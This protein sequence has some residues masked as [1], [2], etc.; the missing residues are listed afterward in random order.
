MRRWT[1]SVLVQIMSCRLGG[2]KPLSEPMQTYCNGI[3]LNSNISIQ[4]NAFKHVVCKVAAIFVQGEMSLAHSSNF[5]YKVNIKTL[6]I[7]FKTMHF[8]H[9]HCKKVY[10]CPRPRCFNR[11]FCSDSIITKWRHHHCPRNITFSRCPE[12]VLPVTTGSTCFSANTMQTMRQQWV[13]SSM[14]LSRILHVMFVCFF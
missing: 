10:P 4:E 7:Y 6:K 14:F 1:G 2:A 13:S 11:L 12:K 3:F 5:S 8:R 9:T